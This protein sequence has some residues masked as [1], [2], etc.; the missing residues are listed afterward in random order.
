MK[1]L[2]PLAVTKLLTYSIDTLNVCD[3]YFHLFACFHCMTFLS[4]MHILFSFLLRSV[5][6]SFAV[7]P[8]PQKQVTIWFEQFLMDK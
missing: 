8:L 4:H 5:T 3:L 6:L 2:F 1:S 7:L